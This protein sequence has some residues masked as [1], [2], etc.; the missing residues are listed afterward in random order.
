MNR[1]IS[2]LKQLRLSQLLS[3]FLAGVALFTITACSSG[4]LQGARPY[5]P[6]VQ[7]GG[8]NNTY[9][10]GGD[11]YTNS[12]QSMPLANPPSNQANF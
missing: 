3:I 9:K 12:D 7:A 4:N 10:R 1:L 8:N 2:F 6:P 11:S 5:N